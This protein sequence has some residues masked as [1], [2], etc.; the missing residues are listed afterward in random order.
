MIKYL[1]SEKESIVAENVL[2]SA[3]LGYHALDVFVVAVI[4]PLFKC[5]KEAKAS[6]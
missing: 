1:Q 5:L 3:K 2:V 6:Y 4:I